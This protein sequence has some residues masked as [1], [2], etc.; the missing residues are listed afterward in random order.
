MWKIYSKFTG[1]HL[2]RSVISPVILLQIFST[3]KNTFGGLL[4]NIVYC[5]MITPWSTHFMPLVPF[6]TPL[7]T[8]EKLWFSNFFRGYRK[9]PKTWNG[10]SKNLSIIAFVAANSTKGNFRRM[11]SFR[12]FPHQFWQS[13]QITAS[14]YR[15]Y[16]EKYGH[17]SPK[18]TL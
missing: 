13:I 10:M 1:E 9:R 14:E 4:L 3:P 7:K 16:F 8:S 5:G 15:I 18:T 11:V 17:G 12:F 6:Y 2:Y